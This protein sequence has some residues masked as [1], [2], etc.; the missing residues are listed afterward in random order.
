[1]PNS[2]NA[3][4]ASPS[5]CS[6]GVCFDAASHLSFNTHQLLEGYFAAPLA[7][8]I[9]VPLNV[10][11]RGRIDLHPQPPEPRVCL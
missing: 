9:V 7:S 8:A 6:R 11:L 2:A 3:S 4:N 5:D 1:M 10:R